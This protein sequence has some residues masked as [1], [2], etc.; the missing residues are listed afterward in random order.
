MLVQ[1]RNLL[2]D[3]AKKLLEKGTITKYDI[4]RIK[5]FG[6]CFAQSRADEGFDKVY[7]QALRLCMDKKQ[8]SVPFLQRNL[9]IG[10]HLAAQIVERMI[11][12]G[13]IRDSY[14]QNTKSYEI[15]N[16]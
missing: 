4:T 14:N 16:R 9:K 11:T 12:D 3:I 8:C 13:Y 15:L 5:S 10:F 1:N 6:E 2:D 7:W